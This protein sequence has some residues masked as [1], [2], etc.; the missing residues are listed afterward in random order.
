MASWPGHVRFYSWEGNFIYVFYSLGLLYGLACLPALNVGRVERGDKWPPG[1]KS[2]F[3]EVA[4]RLTVYT[5]RQARGPGPSC[6]ILHQ[7]MTGFAVHEGSL[8]PVDDCE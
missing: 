6:T 7:Y 2:H 4:L 3:V 5:S 8:M 1:L